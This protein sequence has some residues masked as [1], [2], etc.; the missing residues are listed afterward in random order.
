MNFI[1]SLT[2]ALGLIYFITHYQKLL[3]LIPSYRQDYICEFDPV[4]YIPIEKI[5][6]IKG[7]SKVKQYDHWTYSFH[8]NKKIDEIIPLLQN[9]L[10]IEANQVKINYLHSWIK[11]QIKSS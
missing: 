10:G 9:E 5:Q 7:I 1:I 11:T 4:L 8:M 6:A 2:L 3:R